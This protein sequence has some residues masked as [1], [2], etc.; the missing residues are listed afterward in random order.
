MVVQKRIL[1]DKDFL[2]SENR[3][4]WSRIIGSYPNF[5]TKQILIEY[6]VCLPLT[7]WPCCLLRNQTEY[8][9]KK[10]ISITACRWSSFFCWRQT[11]C[12]TK[13]WPSFI[14]ERMGQW[15]HFDILRPLSL[16]KDDALTRTFG[17]NII[18]RTTCIYYDW[19]IDRLAMTSLRSPKGLCLSNAYTARILTLIFLNKLRRRRL[20]FMYN[21]YITEMDDLFVFALVMYTPG[22]LSGCHGQSYYARR[23][24]TSSCH[25]F[26]S[27][28][29]F[30]SFS[31]Y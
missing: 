2:S 26:A 14:V 13:D 9:T 10:V 19:G 1:S 23:Y 12:W 15:G 20:T 22:S 3:N 4:V 6:I 11:V 21:V 5:C 27:S 8:T 29:F 18:L 7:C 16:L 17:E 25:H 30:F 28:K 31:K 24:V